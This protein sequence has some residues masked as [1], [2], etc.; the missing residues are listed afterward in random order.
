MVTGRAAR[1]LDSFQTR[2][3]EKPMPE[4]LFVSKWAAQRCLISDKYKK[5]GQ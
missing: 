5:I 3:D 1:C 2:S 4:V